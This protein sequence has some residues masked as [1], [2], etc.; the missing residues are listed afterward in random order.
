MQKTSNSQTPIAL[1]M[2]F[3]L[4]TIIYVA[5]CQPATFVRIN[6]DLKQLNP[7]EESSIYKDLESRHPTNYP[8][9]PP[10]RGII[11][12]VKGNLTV[13]VGWM[14]ESSPLGNGVIGVYDSQMNMLDF[15][16]TGPIMSI[17]KVT[18]R[19]SFEVLLV[20][21][22]R[23]T[24]TGIYEETLNVYDI[25]SLK[26]VLWSG[27]AE[28]SYVGVAGG[29]GAYLI[30]SAVVLLNIGENEEKALLVISTNY[31]GPDIE[32]KV[33][34]SPEVKLQVLIPDNKAHILHTNTEEKVEILYP[35]QSNNGNL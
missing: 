6:N 31:E 28:G 34:D 23:I 12:S 1:S 14:T 10:D 26:E 13:W 25:D 20:N 9:W 8:A 27:I 11:K 4:L 24:G 30:H 22:V 19:D 15:K 21:E 2:I 29:V 18:L 17:K 16:I 33:Y 3:V 35:R 32:N 5:G 7:D